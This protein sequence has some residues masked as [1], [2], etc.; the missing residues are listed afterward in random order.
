MPP[1]ASRQGLRRD[2]D[3]R[4]GAPTGWS[5]EILSLLWLFGGRESQLAMRPILKC[6][7]ACVTQ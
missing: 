1:A 4:G 3:Q 7:Y 2:C 6:N 5:L